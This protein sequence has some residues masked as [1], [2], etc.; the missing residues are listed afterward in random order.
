MHDHNQLLTVV[1]V[2]IIT[3]KRACFYLNVHVSDVSPSWP[4]WTVG[5]ISFSVFDH[6]KSG[7]DQSAW[8]SVGAGS[9]AATAPRSGLKHQ[10]PHVSAPSAPG[11]D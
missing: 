1:N 5:S 4:V 10:R 6:V 3:L 2:F 7:R 8:F 11:H 9:A